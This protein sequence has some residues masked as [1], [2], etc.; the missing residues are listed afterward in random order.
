MSN[1]N[2]DE[3]SPVPQELTG[4]F[5]LVLQE[6]ATATAEYGPFHSGHEGYAVMKEELEELWDEIK[7]K[8]IAKARQ[9]AIQVAAM[10]ICFLRDV[11]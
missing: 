7:K 1:T 2:D 10:A 8:Q 9:E 11:R 4:I 5:S 6:I 3:L